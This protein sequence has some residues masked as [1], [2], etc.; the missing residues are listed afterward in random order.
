MAPSTRRKSQI[1]PQTLD[2][3]LASPS[4]SKIG[5]HCAQCDN[6]LGLSNNEWVRLTKSYV[7]A[8]TPGTHSGTE[9]GHKTQVVPNGALHQ[10]VQGCTVVE[11]VC[12]S[13]LAPVGQFCRAVPTT[14]QEYLLGQYFYKLPKIYLKL[15]G[16][17]KK[18]KPIFT[19]AADGSQPRS[20]MAPRES[21]PSVAAAST[22]G[23]S[24]TSSRLISTPSQIQPVSESQPHPSL[25]S[26]QRNGLDPTLNDESSL[27][28]LRLRTYEERLAS[29]S[30][31]LQQQD[32]QIH[33]LTSL[34]NSFRDSMEDMKAS[35][36]DLRS[37]S[38]ILQTD[39]LSRNSLF[40]ATHTPG[41]GTTHA[42]SGS[43]EVEQL[44]A[45]NARMK[46]RLEG[47][48]SA[49]GVELE[50]PSPAVLDERPNGSSRDLLGKRKRFEIH[51]GSAS[52]VSSTSAQKRR[53]STLPP[54]ASKAGQSEE[55][56]NDEAERTNTT[57]SDPLLQPK[58]LE[59]RQPDDERQ[60]LPSKDRVLKPHRRE[61]NRLPTGSPKTFADLDPVPHSRSRLS[62]AETVEF[63]DDDLAV[64]LY[65]RKAN[66]NA[67]LGRE[68]TQ[69]N[70]GKVQ[71][72]APLRAVPPKRPRGRPRKVAKEPTETNDQ[73]S[74]APISA[75][76]KP[77]RSTGEA[78]VA[79]ENGTGVD[80]PEQDLP[81]AMH[82]PL[83][84]GDGTGV[85]KGAK[86]APSNSVPDTEDELV[87]SA[88][89]LTGTTPSAT[90]EK[91][92]E[93]ETSSTSEANKTS[94]KQRMEEI[95]RRDQLAKEAM[96]MDD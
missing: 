28:E 46:A 40:G 73:Q 59:A 1:Q 71:H 75:V 78:D 21:R 65:L 81:P 63:S 33:L 34:V 19:R 8:A 55:D 62:V 93:L 5:L 29:Q 60:S 88:E 15:S 53:I 94:R 67:N 91:A 72:H 36:R 24:Q 25:H 27:L 96:E 52:I 4:T 90:A 7:L 38:G 70:L 47:I 48:A 57:V 66:N 80:H 12:T 76:T 77:V 32:T 10:T 31:R 17:N 43:G 22:P 89:Q 87:S 82:T 11:V 13:C 45:E 23:L 92:D 64:D 39:P 85:T 14:E 16:T 51:A 86:K 56:H 20:S 74:V 69:D 83:L 3:K 79:A 37:R 50:S 61:I 54:A 84:E 26:Q 35:L 18:V 44:R 68:Q 9:V 58:N 6:E 41:T 95:L 2:P 30:A 42:H 49:M